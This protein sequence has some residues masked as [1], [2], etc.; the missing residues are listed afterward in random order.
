MQAVA[1]LEDKILYFDGENWVLEGQKIPISSFPLY[2]KSC[3][4]KYGY[5]VVNDELYESLDI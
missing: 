2:A 5:E 3:V 1:R 4:E